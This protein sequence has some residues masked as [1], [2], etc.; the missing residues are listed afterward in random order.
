MYYSFHIQNLS[1]Q[2]HL[3]SLENK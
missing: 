3:L 1:S 2:K